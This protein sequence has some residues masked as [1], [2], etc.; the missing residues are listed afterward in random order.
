MLITDLVVLNVVH[1]FLLV[2][3]VVELIV[4][5][6]CCCWIILLDIGALVALDFCRWFCCTSPLLM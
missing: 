1:G 4:L 5:Y 6:R 3:V 2:D